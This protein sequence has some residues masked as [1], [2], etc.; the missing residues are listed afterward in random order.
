MASSE[1]Q[2]AV[3]SGGGEKGK[4]CPHIVE[5]RR[6]RRRDILSAS[7]GQKLEERV[8]PF[9]C[10]CNGAKSSPGQFG[11]TCLQNCCQNYAAMMGH[12]GGGV[13]EAPQ[14]N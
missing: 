12:W 7:S 6:W 8:C 4:C 1:G 9:C 14:Y 11:G 10:F 2:L 3:S 5:S 13:T